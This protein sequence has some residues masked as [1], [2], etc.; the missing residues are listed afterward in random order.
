MSLLL[1]LYTIWISKSGE[2]GR[3]YITNSS[4]IEEEAY[5]NGV[6]V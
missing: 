5:L 2:K 1:D 4:S 6:L 3:L